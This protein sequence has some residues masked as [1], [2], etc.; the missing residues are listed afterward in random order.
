MWR[1]RASTFAG[2]MMGV[3]SLAPGFAADPPAGQ[4]KAIGQIKKISGT[5]AIGR[6]GAHLPAK[7]GAPLY[8]GDVLE[9]GPDGSVGVTLADNS[10]LSAGPSAELALPEFNFD[11]NSLRGS[12]QANLR[13][14]TLT[15]VSGE[16]TH[17]T[18]GA[19]SVRTPT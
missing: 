10:L 3:L 14:G 18:P 4:A 11:S 7:P 8:Q 19:M 2:R 6:A 16:I 15:A 9:T 13:R 12:M 1:G 17:A 5:V